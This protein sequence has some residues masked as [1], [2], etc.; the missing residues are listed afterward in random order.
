MEKYLLAE[1]LFKS[2]GF[3]ILNKMEFDFFVPASFFYSIPQKWFNFPS[4]SYK[5]RISHMKRNIFWKKL[6]LK[7][8]RRESS[9]ICETVKEKSK[10][11][12]KMEL[13]MWI[14]HFD[15]LE[16]LKEFLET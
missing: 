2:T 6:E 14:K 7:P 12:W 9:K 10:M 5:N 16:W 11:K 4:S 1:S 13:K 8:E 15:N 3:K